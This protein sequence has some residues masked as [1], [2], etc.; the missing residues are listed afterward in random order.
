MKRIYLDHGEAYGNLGDEAMLINASRRLQKALGDVEFVIPRAGDAPLPDIEGATH[1]TSPNPALRRLMRRLVPLG[2]IREWFHELNWDPLALLTPFLMRVLGGTEEWKNMLGYLSRCDGLYLVGAANL[3]DFARLPCVLPKYALVCEALTRDIPVVVSSQTVG[4]LSIPWVQRA[5][6]RMVNQADSFTTRDRGVTRDFLTEAGV[7]SSAV[8]F[9][10]DEAFTLPTASEQRVTSYLQESGIGSSESIS[11]IHFRGTDYTQ[12]TEQYYDTLASAFDSIDTQSRLCFVPMSYGEHSGDDEACGNAI[13]DRMKAPEK[14][15]V[16][17]ASTEVKIVRGL[18][19]RAEWMLGLSYHTQIFAL[20]AACP[21]GLLASGEY[22][23]TKA[24]GVHNIVNRRMPFLSMSEATPRDIVETME[25]LKT[26]R[27]S[28]ED[29]LRKV[30]NNVLDVND[31][32][33]QAMKSAL[34]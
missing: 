20:S 29:Y 14:L 19:S 4:P 13:R 32:P 7:N 2:R 26:N 23:H 34:Q 25:D 22:Y 3:N 1:V 27:S 18:F 31:R 17:D 6:R 33:V 21:F 28:Y 24:R 30:R 11:L 5:V 12:Q 15:T 9:S 8:T 10:G 16:L